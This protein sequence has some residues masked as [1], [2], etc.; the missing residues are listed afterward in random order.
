[1]EMLNQMNLKGILVVGSIVGIIVLVVIIPNNAKNTSPSL[2]DNPI[3]NDSVLVNSQLP[4][5]ETLHI[6]DRS[7]V[8]KPSETDHYI[9]ENGTRHYIIKAK[10]DV[11]TSE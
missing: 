9:D 2:S 4:L 7:G 6:E 8:E 1:M 10:D 3:I 5:N 11:K